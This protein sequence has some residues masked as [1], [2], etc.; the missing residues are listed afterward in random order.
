MKI[1]RTKDY[2]DMGRKA[3]NIVAAQVILKEDSVLGLATGSTMVGLYEELASRY[4]LGDLDFS[5]ARTVNLDEYLGLHPSNSQSY[6]YYMDKNLF[7]R[8]NI[9]PQNTHLPSGMADDTDMECAAYDALIE[10]LGGI[11]LQ[12]LGL[13]LDG[14]I[15]FN[16]PGEIFFNN[17]HC[18]L[19]DESTIKANSRF[20]EHEDDVPRHALTMGIGAIMKAKTVLLCVNGIAKA[21]ILKEVLYG[22]ITPEVPGSILQLHPH[23]IVVADEEALSE[24]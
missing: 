14:H 16:E 9:L 8:I 5:K 11:D 15:G 12:L 23:L 17:S 6:R 19:L 7:S 3:A 4:C 24:I 21:S 18:I 22:P 20:F 10:S 2:Q 13:G 1:I